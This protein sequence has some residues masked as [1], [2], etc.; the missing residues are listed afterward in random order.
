L[1]K[2]GTIYLKNCGGLNQVITKAAKITNYTDYEK[3]YSK[4]YG[5]RNITYFFRGNINNLN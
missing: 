3:E 4:L 5:R 2:N 1:F